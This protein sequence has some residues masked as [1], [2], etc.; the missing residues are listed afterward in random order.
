VANIEHLNCSSA[1]IPAIILSEKST[2]L[3]GSRQPATTTI[4]R[5]GFVRHA[6]KLLCS[7]QHP[8]V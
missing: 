6:N 7:R 8:P 3:R 4:D 5:S 1:V 2:F